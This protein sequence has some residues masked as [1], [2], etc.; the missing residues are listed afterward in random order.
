MNDII[1]VASIVS[2]TLS[3]GLGAIGP[4]LGRYRIGV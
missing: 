3:V 2:A 1:Q 4:A